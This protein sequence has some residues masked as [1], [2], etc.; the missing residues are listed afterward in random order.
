MTERPVW[1]TQ[2]LH[3]P[4][5]SREQDQVPAL[6]EGTFQKCATGS[7]VNPNHRQVLSQGR[8][9]DRTECGPLWGPSC[10]GWVGHQGVAPQR[11]AGS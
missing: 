3:V 7:K 6:M 11:S 5:R 10:L 1:A 4:E 9:M 2:L 8:E